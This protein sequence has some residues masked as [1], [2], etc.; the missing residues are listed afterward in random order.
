MDE[1]T[2]D[3]SGGGSVGFH[4]RAVNMRGGA[5]S[6]FVLDPTSAPCAS[7]RRMHATCFALAAACRAVRPPCGSFVGILAN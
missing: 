5:A 7:R 4:T 1:L 2:G 6:T 3:R